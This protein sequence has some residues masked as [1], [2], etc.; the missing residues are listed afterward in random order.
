MTLQSNLVFGFRK[1]ISPFGGNPAGEASR[2]G[3]PATR[4]STNRG[5]GP[6]DPHVGSGNRRAAHRTTWS[7]QRDRTPLAVRQSQ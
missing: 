2:S 1:G 5:P 3:R 6:L 4:Q 7:H